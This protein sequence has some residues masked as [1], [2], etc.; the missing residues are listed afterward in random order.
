[1]LAFQA[2]CLSYSKTHISISRAGT[3]VSLYNIYVSNA[4][5]EIRQSLLDKRSTRL[6]KR[7]TCQKYFFKKA[8]S[9]LCK[10]TVATMSVSRKSIPNLRWKTAF[11]YNLSVNFNLSSKKKQEILFIIPRKPKYRL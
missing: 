9:P 11:R 1:M 4:S 3:S 7:A 10:N 5:C 2:N 8:N 6:F